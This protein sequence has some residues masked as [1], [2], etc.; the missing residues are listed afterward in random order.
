MEYNHGET[1]RTGNNTYSNGRVV[2]VKNSAAST[3]YADQ[4]EN[5]EDYEKT[6]DKQ[7][8]K[9]FLLLKDVKLNKYYQY[10]K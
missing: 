6:D 7:V 10:T 2:K 3:S 9:Q 8:F 4:R 1:K 5:C